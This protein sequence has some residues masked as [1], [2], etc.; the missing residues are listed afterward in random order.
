MKGC[1]IFAPLAAAL[2]CT[3]SARAELS[4]ETLAQRCLTSL[5]NT[6]QDRALYRKAWWWNG[7]TKTSA[8][9]ISRPSSPRSSIIQ[10]A[11]TLRC[12]ACWKTINRYMSGQERRLP[13]ARKQGWRY[14]DTTQINA[15]ASPNR[16]SS[17]AARSLQNRSRAI[18]AIS[19]RPAM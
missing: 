3:T 12:F 1:F 2:F 10:C 6:W 18:F 5:I 4:E 9:S 14:A 17:R 13:P 11:K 19:K 16:R 15:K 8:N 7:M